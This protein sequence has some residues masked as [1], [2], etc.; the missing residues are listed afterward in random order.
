MGIWS[1]L[2]SALMPRDEKSSLS[3][4][5]TSDAAARSPGDAAVA[6]LEPPPEPEPL[7]DPVPAERW[8]APEGATLLEPPPFPRPT[9]TT[10]VM[11]LENLLVS[12]FDGHDL[13]L[14]PLQHIAERVL[15]RIRDP[16]SDLKQ[17][18]EEISEDQVMAASVLR[19]A[20]SPLFRGLHKVTAL[21]P[22]VTR[23]G[24]KALRTLMMHQSIRSMMF[25]S[26]GENA[27]FAERLWL[28]SVASACIT[29]M[30][31]RFTSV[32]EEDAFLIGLLHDI[33]NVIV[34]RIV[35]KNPYASLYEIDVDVF[36]YL[37]YECHHEF[38]ELIA[39]AWKLPATVKSLISDH[40]THP[41]A[42][43]PLRSE[44]LLLLLADMINA[45]LGYA[46]SV[47]YDLLNTHVVAEL[48]L[49]DRPDFIKFLGALPQKVEEA[50]AE[51]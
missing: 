49:A 2:T 33:G 42:D 40:H 17:I 11:A 14:P 1:W 31:S 21:R 45:M 12:H 39:D 16:K 30:L 22:A 13:T 51:L 18:A 37:C 15:K 46:P 24:T 8:W 25:S 44:R 4:D 48:R 38:G 23:L 29:R 5:G 28:R 6:V 20:N 10:E 35:L 47:S 27:F 26:N 43:D 34:L 32:N 9:L 36:E 3:T 50:V 19:M 7:D 41:A